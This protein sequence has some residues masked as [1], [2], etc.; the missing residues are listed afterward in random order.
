MA[1]ALRERWGRIHALATRERFRSRGFGWDGAAPKDAMPATAQAPTPSEPGKDFVESGSDAQ[2]RRIT[3]RTVTI[4][5][6]NERKEDRRQDDPQ[7]KKSY[8][9]QREN[10]GV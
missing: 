3:V 7:D 10:D 5:R 2:R 1:S 8:E 4:G 6:Q 9:D